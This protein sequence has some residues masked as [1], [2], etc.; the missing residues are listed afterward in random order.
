MS[1]GVIR[2][3]GDRIRKKNVKRD[4][5]PDDDMRTRIVFIT[6]NIPRDAIEN[7]FNCMT[8]R[9]KNKTEY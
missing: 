1:Q 3:S 5:W 6:H 4:D 8:Q 9:D 7:L 2:R